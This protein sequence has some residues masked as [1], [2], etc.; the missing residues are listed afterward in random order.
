MDIVNE[1]NVLKSK[2]VNVF[3]YTRLKVGNGNSTLFWDNNWIG[4]TT[5]KAKFSRLYALENDKSVL[6]SSKMEALSLDSSF[7]RKARAGIE[8]SKYNDLIDLVREVSLVPCEDRWVWSL[9]SGGLFGGFD[10]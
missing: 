8:L 10:S 2:G 7:R 9:E 1:V 4:G 3:E 5:L 6:L